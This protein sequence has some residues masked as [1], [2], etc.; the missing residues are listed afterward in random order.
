M[1]FWLPFL[2]HLQLHYFSRFKTRLRIRF[3]NVIPDLPRPSRGA[4]TRPPPSPGRRTSRSRRPSC[5]SSRWRSGRE[6]SPPPPPPPPPSRRRTRPLRRCPGRRAC[7]NSGWSPLYNISWQKIS[8]C[9]ILFSQERRRE[10]GCLDRPPNLPRLLLRP[11]CGK[12][13]RNAGVA[14]EERQ[15]NI[16]WTKL[17]FPA[18]VAQPVAFAFP[19]GGPGSNPP[20]GRGI[21]RSK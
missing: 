12:V 18:P 13:L 6:T 16:R 11:H 1:P 3:D 9:F 20:Q 15:V 5:S 4:P 17:G 2:N 14:R 10:E 21:T 19:L 7:L 8:I